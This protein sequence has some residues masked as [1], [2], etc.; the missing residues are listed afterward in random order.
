LIHALGT[1]N[2]GNGR[3][4]TFVAAARWEQVHWSDREQVLSKIAR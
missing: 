1:I 2:V 4:E 3:Q